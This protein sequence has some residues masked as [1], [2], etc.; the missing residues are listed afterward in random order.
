VRVEAY[1][2]D[3][4]AAWDEFVAQSK[5]GVFLFRRDYMDYHSDRFN[6]A[7]LMIYD[8]KDLV[9]LLPANRDED[10]VQ[11]HGGLTYGGVITS[12]RMSTCKFLDVFES[13]LSHLRSEGVKQLDYK[14]VPSIY[15]VVPAE[16][17]RYALFLAGAPCYRRDASA[18]LEPSRHPR[19]RKGRKSEI[20][21]A[22][23]VGLVAEES[24]QWADFWQV[25]EDNLR[26]R[27]GLGPVH[28]LE[29]MLLLHERFPRNIRLF[30]VRGSDGLHA[31]TVVY[32]TRRVAHTQYISC[33][34]RGQESGALSLLFAHL[35]D[36]VYRDK[37][38]FDFGH[39]NENGGLYLNRGLAEF[40][41]GFGAR[42]VVYES[43][44]VDLDTVDLSALRAERRDD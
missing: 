9:A 42:A 37:P 31:G 12:D 21:K 1:N 27:Y 24:D 30:V 33:A 2:R 15:H 3:T 36:E 10:T 14:P 5:N 4:Q 43:Y 40:K 41:E 25:L 6:D 22:R 13:I 26:A 39:S 23:R 16:E 32:E 35:I 19:F 38:V 44:R 11:S 29:E 20:S 8:S 7:S 28:T 34:Q 17:D 18:T